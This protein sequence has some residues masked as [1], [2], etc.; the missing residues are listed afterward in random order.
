MLPAL[1]VLREELAL[2]P[3]PVLADGQP[4]WILQDPARNQFFRLD[5]LT[6]EILSRWSLRQPDLIARAVRTATTLR[7]KAADVM[8][9]RDFLVDNQLVRP[10]GPES[11]QAMTKAYATR[12]T[13]PLLWL[14]RH[15]LFFRVPLVR[16]D[17]W[18]ARW[19]GVA[20]WFGGVFFR[21]LTL[22][23]L[24]V[25]LVQGVRHSGVF[26]TTLVDTFTWQGLWAYGAAL[27]VV[28][29]LHELGHAFAAKRQGCHV[30]AMGIAFL[31]L[32]PMP[33]TD[34]NEAWRLTRRGERLRVACGGI[35]TELTLGA[36]ALF[37]WSWLPDGPARQIAF[38][39]CTTSLLATLAI[40]V[41]PFLRFDGYFILSDW[42][43]LPNLH[44]RSF[45][46]ARWDLRERL[47]AAGEEP[48]EYFSR[49]QTRGL[50][51]FAWATWLYRLTVFIG[52]AILIY[53]FFIKVVALVLFVVEILWF[54]LWPIFREMQV[55]HKMW[56]QWRKRTA[57]RRRAGWTLLILLTGLGLVAW[58]WPGRVSSQGWLRPAQMQVVYA[59]GAGQVLEWPWADGAEVPAGEILV[60][61]HAAEV[62]AQVELARLR[63]GQ[64]RWQAEALS[65]TPGGRAQWQ[66]GGEQAATAAKE[67]EH[68]ARELERYA[69]RA[70]FTGQWREA[71]PDG[72]PGW[73]VARNEVLGTLVDE[74]HWVVELYLDEEQ[75]K[76]VAVGDRAFFLTVRGW[77]G[78][79]KLR[80]RQIDADATRVLPDGRLAARHG[81][82][83]LTRESAAGHVP[84]QAVYRVLLEVVSEVGELAHQQWRG[85]VTVHTAPY[86]RVAR[87]LRQ[88]AMVVLR[89]SGF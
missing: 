67:W 10:L 7:A 24:A 56:P 41:S 15:Y 44:A 36:W 61:L 86:S 48:P 3:G 84:E 18:L 66:A 32:W 42:L 75:V 23:A 68:W 30:P 58:P 46:L 33:Y 81:G 17:A 63:A 76:R 8:A 65:L 20:A 19:Q 54:I 51:L 31:V 25:G 85:R 52:I 60:R 1:P 83:V 29:A 89:E 70:N 5:W 11:T 9:V 4:S 16:P 74:R 80:V 14:L 50:I 62:E 88:A 28:K 82:S 87:Y 43:N 2:L 38:V 73:W 79:L 27:I 77:G 78:A 47:F 69:P 53:H 21:T 37:V 6:F 55:W 45:A 49:R 34:T 57:S 72:V 71:L 39:L 12:Q 13:H 26:F 59:P 35:V 64:L 22:L 40:N